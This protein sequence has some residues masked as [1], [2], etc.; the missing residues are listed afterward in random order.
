LRGKKPQTASSLASIRVPSQLGLN[1]DKPHLTYNGHVISVVYAA[2][3]FL[4]LHNFW[5]W[6]SY[7]SV[8]DV[9]SML[10]A[11]ALQAVGD[12]YSQSTCRVA[13]FKGLFLREEREKGIREGQCMCVLCVC[14]SVCRQHWC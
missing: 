2:E 4:N 6:L 5:L 7:F 14:V 3:F 11:R 1:A 8:T 9:I 12:H 10:L 13:V